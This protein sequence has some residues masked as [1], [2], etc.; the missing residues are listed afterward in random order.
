MKKLDQNQM[1]NQNFILTILATTSNLRK[2]SMYNFSKLAVAN[3]VSQCSIFAHVLLQ[4]LKG[5][6]IARGKE[7]KIKK[8]IKTL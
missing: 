7:S 6:K 4:K 1:L 2:R 8:K 5:K 3:V